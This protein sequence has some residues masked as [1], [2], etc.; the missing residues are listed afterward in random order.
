MKKLI[1]PLIAICV[2]SCS[3]VI[4]RYLY[5]KEQHQAA[6]S[7]SYSSSTMPE[8]YHEIVKNSDPFTL[9]GRNNEIVAILEQRLKNEPGNLRLQFITG[10]Q[11]IFNGTTQRGLDLLLPLE[12]NQEFLTNKKLLVKNDN[13]WSVVDSLENF[14]ALAYLRLGEQTNCIDNHNGQSCVFPISGAGI[15]QHKDP[16]REAITRYLALIQKNPDD[17]L[18]VWLLNVACQAYGSVPPEVPSSLIIPQSRLNNE[19]DCPRFNDIA[20]DLG[21][22]NPGWA[23]GIIADDFDND[24]YLDIMSSGTHLNTQIRYYHNNGNGTFTDYTERAHLSGVWEGL[25]I[26]PVD[27]NNDGW[28]DFFLP[29]GGWKYKAGFL[30]PSLMRNNGDGTFTDVTIEA[31]LMNFHPSQTAE[32]A[33]ADLDGDMD[34]FLGHEM[35]TQS[36]FYR[37]NGDGTFTDISEESGISFKGYVKGANW[38]DYN[39]DGL[40]DLYVSQF[41]KRC[42]LFRNDGLDEHGMIHFT[43][44]TKE[45]GVP[46][47]KS[48]FPCWWFDYNNDGWQDIYVSAYQ[49]GYTINS[50]R[51]FMGLPMDSNL[52]PKLYRNNGDGTFTD[53][54]KK[55][56]LGYETF[57]MGCNFGDLDN[58]GWLDFYLGIGAPDYKAIFPNRMFHNH[59]GQFFE[60][61]T[62]SGGF[63][64]LQKG[65]AISFC[66]LDYD[67]DQDVYADFGGFYWG[68]IFG[69]ALYENPGFGNHWVNIRFEGVKNNRY[70]VD[71]IVKLT[72]TENGK[73]RT[74]YSKIGHGASFGAN[75]LRLQAGVGKA[76]VIDEVDVYWPATKTHQVF[77]NVPVDRV[78]WCREGETELNEMPVHPFQ[79]KTMERR[80]AEG[81]TT[82]MSHMHH[83]NM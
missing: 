77:R 33:D 32:F 27:Y 49:P 64:Q 75:P 79:F 47:Q 15:H 74:T 20:V 38:G 82:N 62:I 26:F 50:C 71:N 34:L 58:D 25:D 9:Y 80:M 59:G 30:P 6:V 73:Q 53:V 37:N 22:D 72:F 42:I 29:R 44:V 7:V 66:D 24:G 1:L 18:S 57:T 35:G 12:K 4:G 17:H 60:D 40:P 78:Y 69:N 8:I 3:G 19:W 48:N 23:G 46:G 2:V 65:H 56:H 51:E 61:C 13:G 5:L 31:G 10:I 36:N 55:M 45:A 41:K 11:N 70:G 67:G 83:M 43:D 16:V 39:N 63:G 68:D 21:I 54:A 76:T 14:L 52:F 28:L 81:D